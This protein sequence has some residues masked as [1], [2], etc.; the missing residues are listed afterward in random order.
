MRQMFCIKSALVKK[1]LLD[2]FNK[3]YRMRYLEINAFVKMQYERN[4]PASWKNDKSVLCKMPPRVEPTNFK[5]QDDEMT[6]G[7]FVIRFEHKFVRNIY[8]SE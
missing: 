1:I 5:R 7:D 8:T 4:N 6:Y 3:K 2:W